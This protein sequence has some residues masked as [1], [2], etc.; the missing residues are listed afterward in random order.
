MQM[1]GMER[2]TEYGT[3]LLG[4]DTFE[5]LGE[6]ADQET[7]HKIFDPVMEQV[8]KAAGDMYSKS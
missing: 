5:V 4:Q 6:V 3:A 7:L 2:E 8:K 1:S